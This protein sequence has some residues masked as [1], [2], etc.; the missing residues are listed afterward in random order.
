MYF[1]EGT[2][3]HPLLLTLLPS[4][5]PL[6]PFPCLLPPLLPPLQRF[7]M[8]KQAFCVKFMLFV[9]PSWSRLGALLGPLGLL[10][11]SKKNLQRAPR[12]H[13][14]KPER[15][16][17]PRRPAGPRER[18]SHPAPGEAAPPAPI[19]LLPLFLVFFVDCLIDCRPAQFSFHSGFRSP[20]GALSEPSWGAFGALREP[21]QGP[22]RRPRESRI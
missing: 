5:L 15:W 8:M 12:R 9:L 22:E 17:S 19:P 10:W 6:L 20:L 14:K 1:Q 13:P 21:F 11:D 16:Q 4:S 7:D 18:D 2:T 3:F